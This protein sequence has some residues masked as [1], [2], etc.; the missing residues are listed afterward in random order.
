MK[1]QICLTVI[2]TCLCALANA[3]WKQVSGYST[4]GNASSMVVINDTIIVSS[5]GNA[6]DGIPGLFTSTDH[7][8]SWSAKNTSLGM[9]AAPLLLY[10]GSLYAGTTAHG[11]YLSADKGNSW[12]PKN[13]GL[14]AGFPV[15]D[16]EVNN[17]DFFACGTGGIF[18][19]SDYTDNWE[20]ISLAGTVQAAS[21]IG[22]GD[23][24][25]SAFVSLTAA[26]VYKSTDNGT[27]WTL[28]NTASG[29]TDTRIRKFAVFYHILFAAADGDLGTGNIYTSA[30]NGINW[31]AAHGL[32]DQGHNYPYNFTVSGNTV[33]LATSNGVYK[34][35]DN[36]LNWTNTGCTNAISLAVL[37]DTL[38][39]GTGFHGI[40]KRGLSEMIGGTED[41]KDNRGFAVY[42]N[43]SSDKITIE[44]RRYTSL[45]KIQVSIYD[46]QDRLVLQHPVQENKTEIDVRG[47]E[48]G[49]YIIKVTIKGMTE[50][51]KFVK[52]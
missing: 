11:V 42:P 37:G 32:S 50:S 30:D 46:I 47:L 41:M 23:T 39:A 9:S 3:Q 5:T 6:Y 12:I 10:G 20:D 49:F 4:N 26:G 19:S 16:L 48:K 38:F 21:V 28:I 29:L 13:N 31:T 14:P 8:V 35:I 36:G 2:L 15:F 22:F 17:S 52:N 34:S 7:G 24:I 27:G 25:I 43:P 18:H 33:F 45:K 1:N 51:T 44:L 40:W